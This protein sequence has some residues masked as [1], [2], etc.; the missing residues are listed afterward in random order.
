MIRTV[1]TP[2]PPSTLIAATGLKAG[3]IYAAFGSKAALFDQVVDRYQ[4]AVSGAYVDDA[5]VAEGIA[6]EAAMG[7]GR[8]ELLDMVALLTARLPWE[9]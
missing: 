5:T 4:R 1:Q 8:A 3:S 9:R 2:N 6:V 7:V